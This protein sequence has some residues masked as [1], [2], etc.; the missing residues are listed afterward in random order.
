MNIE[1]IMFK[2]MP[3][4]I[5]HKTR[6][7]IFRIIPFGV[8][9]LVV[10]TLFLFS[11][12][13]ATGNQ[14]RNPDTDITLTV[15]IFIFASLAVFIVGIVMG[16][17]EMIIL[18]RRFSRYSLTKKI[19]YK[20]L[21]Y[22]GF[23]IVIIGITY[24]IAASMELGIPITS[25]EIWDKASLFFW[26]LTF[27]STIVQTSFSI[28][29]CLVYSAVSENLGQHVLFNFFTGKY[30]QPVVEERIFLFMDLTSSTA[31]AEQLGHYT[32]FGLLDLFYTSMSD[33]IID[34]QG[35]V[36][37]YIGDEV[38]VTWPLKKGVRNGNCIKCFYAIK[39]AMKSKEG[40]FMDRYGIFPHFKG[41][42]HVGEVTTGE[43]GALK[44]E[45]VFTGDVMN[46]TARIQWLCKTYGSDLLVSGELREL[47]IDREDI[48]FI[49]R[50][51]SEL[52]GKKKLI[53]VYECKLN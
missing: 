10:G 32:Y 46:T 28:F 38:I 16:I 37:E 17:I 40:K 31:I 51:E 4:N 21:I 47:F 52:R 9:W 14:N 23:I 15:P 29:L 35:E 41:D 2:P 12:S 5:S 24:P 34:H 45:I 6:R 53:K 42:I 39:K 27:V 43:I 22:I 26:S 13:V 11:E 19:I 7:N 44:K 50:D 1:C 49:E 33:A 3:F 48:Q 20:S 30:H 36:Y 18:E 25:G 8:I